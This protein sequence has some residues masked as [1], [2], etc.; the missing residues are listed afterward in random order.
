MIKL[1]LSLLTIVSSSC[2]I[3]VTSE[4]G[5]KD[6]NTT[7][8]IIQCDGVPEAQAA[9]LGSSGF[10]STLHYAIRCDGEWDTQQIGKSENGNFRNMS[11]S[12]GADYSPSFDRSR[13][14]P[15]WWGGG[16]CGHI[17]TSHCQT[18]E[19]FFKM[20]CFRD[21]LK[22]LFNDRIFWERRHY[23]FE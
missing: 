18:A 11:F 1:L 7:S 17:P 4:D 5:D 12:I 16:V 9:W 3:T 23:D 8:Q 10:R 14:N 21:L 13:S 22:S 19:I 15:W 20:F 2:G 6:K